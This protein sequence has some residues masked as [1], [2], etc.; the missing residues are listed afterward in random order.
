[1]SH[2]IQEY[3]KICGVKIGEP[4]LI[5]SFYPI[6][7]EKYI[8]IHHATCAATT[9]NYWEEVLSILKPIL[10]KK[11]INIVQILEND[12]SKIESCDKHIFCTK[13]Q[14]SHVIR[15]SI[16][17]IGVDS[18]FCHFAAKHN[19]PLV[20]IYSHTNP[21]NTCPWN[22]NKKLVKEIIAFDKNGRPSYDIN[23]NPKTI[24]SIYPEEIVKNLFDLIGI[25]NK[26]KFKTL[27]IGERYKE[28]C[29]DIV[30]IKK[31]N[32][33]CNNIN[34]RMDIHHDEN[35]LI[36][37]IS[38][39]IVEVTLSNPI[40]IEILKSKRINTINYLGKEFDKNFVE[41][42]KSFGINLN[43]ICVDKNTVDDQRFKFFDYNI[44]LHD[45]DSIIEEKSKIFSE[46]SIPDLNAK[47]NKKIIIGDA[48]YFTY[49]EAL[50]ST[51][52]FLL[53][54]DWLYLYTSK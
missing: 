25:K 44:I 9:Y 32:I 3:A 5:D 34:V 37:V 46:I 52:L 45:L 11:N 28:S 27:L 16:C 22:F 13:K 50:K 1:M 30:P 48:V 12:A 21:R 18:I 54:L 14:A 8:T 29:V 51:V 2:L 40:S 10:K 47:S 20:S 49:I 7:F 19:V 6:E 39:N 31:T 38:R 24:N 42:V 41:L 33:S 15:N 53:D 4:I 35:V 23:E 36:D 26:I 43:L 17:H